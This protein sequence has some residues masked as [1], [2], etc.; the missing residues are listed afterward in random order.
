[1]MAMIFFRFLPNLLEDGPAGLWMSAAFGPA[2]C[3]ILILAWWLAASRA[4]WRERMLGLVGVLLSAF[5]CI[6]LMHPTMLGPAVT[7]LTIPMGMACFGLGTILFA[8]LQS[9]KR[10]IFAILLA[11]AGFGF[12]L[13]LRSE[14]MWGD[15]APAF[16]WRWTPSAE[17]ELL[18]HTEDRASVDLD[19]LDLNRLEYSLL[20][21]EWSGFRGPDRTG[22]QSGPALATNW[23]QRPPRQ[24]WKISVGP[25]WSSF[26]VAG[27]LIFTQ[28]QRG[29][30]ETVVAYTAATGAEVWTQQ[31]QSRFDD[32]LGGPGPRATPTIAN[33]SLFVLGAEGFLLRLD[34][35]T[36]EI[37]WQHELQK[38]ADRTP[39]MWGFSSSP[40]VVDDLVIVHAGGAGDKGILAFASNSGELRWSAPSGSHSYSS[41][42]LCQVAGE[43]LLIM[44]SDDGFEAYAPQSGEIRLR[45]SWPV[46]GGYRSLQT[47]VVEKDSIL[48]PTGQGFGTRRVR[49]A[50]S[51]GELTAAEVWTS[52]QLKP[53]YNDLVVFEGHAYG[54]DGLAFTCIDLADGQRKWKGGRY[55]KGQVLLLANMGALLVATETGEI[56]LVEATPTAHKE[57]CR[58]QAVDGKTWNH[59][60]VVGDRLYIRNAEEAACYQLPTVEEV[61]GDAPTE[62]EVL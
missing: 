40:L 42:Q 47:H 56:V 28:E 22:S 3:S 55:G 54:F 60:V 2:L 6:S 31:I 26:A 13:S 41:P 29:E 37:I 1:M 50:H 16:G 43:D 45:Y 25:A 4:S 48:I 19:E 23:D 46:Q 51:N 53:D 15:F 58:F 38:L 20:N 7:V 24:L 36:G 5:I 59:P 33:G 11:L 18:A 52:R 49:L 44:M 17:E 57:L 32:P 61:S 8:R 62:N 27:G 14:G 30:F 10:T 9:S 12:S 39:P 21:P 35:K 34:P